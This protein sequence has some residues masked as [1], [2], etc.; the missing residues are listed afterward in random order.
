VNIAVLL[1]ADVAGVVTLFCVNTRISTGPSRIL[2]EFLAKYQ[3]GPTHLTDER[4]REEHQA[5]P[6]NEP[7]RP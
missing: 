4:L 5:S 2:N 3:A 1:G 6:L 7:D